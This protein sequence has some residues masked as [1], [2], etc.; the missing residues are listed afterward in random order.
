M[1]P[2]EAQVRLH[3]ENAIKRENANVTMGS[4]KLTQLANQKTLRNAQTVSQN[5]LSATCPKIKYNTNAK[6][7]LTEME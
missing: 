6:K 5:M 2:L 1:L 7:D 3:L 4:R